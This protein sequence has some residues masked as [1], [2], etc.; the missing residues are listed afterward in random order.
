[1]N[2]SS[3]PCAIVN[4]RLLLFNE[5]NITHICN[6]H[7][8]PAW[9]TGGGIVGGTGG[10]AL[11]CTGGGKLRIRSSA[12]RCLK[13]GG[14]DSHSPTPPRCPT[15]SRNPAMD[16]FWPTEPLC[17]REVTYEG[18]KSRLDPHFWPIFKAIHVYLLI[19]TL[20]YGCWVLKY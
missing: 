7:R 10:G 11:Q 15:L 5:I 17:P 2:T 14:P 13:N 12:H 8:F 3:I 6:S 9:W 19:A 20:V 4:E 16:T 18:C 1:M